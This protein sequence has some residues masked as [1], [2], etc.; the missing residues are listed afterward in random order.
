[1]KITDLALEGV[2]LLEPVY[3]EDNRGSGSEVH[4]HRTLSAQGIHNIFVQDY[5]NLNVHAGTLRGIHYQNYPHAQAKIIRCLKGKFLDIVVDLR[6][7]SPTYKQ[8]ITT[9]ISA[10]NKKQIFIPKGFG[11]GFVTLEDNTEVFYKMDEYY[12]HGYDGA[13]LWNDS[14]LAI[15]WGTTNPILSDKDLKAPILA[16]STINF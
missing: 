6:K 7:N 4:S 3:Y 11:H 12:A 1:M 9:E 13:I 10:E 8:Y 5:F 14:E 16:E 2:K 15:E